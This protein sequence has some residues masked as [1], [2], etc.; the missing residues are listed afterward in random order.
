MNARDEILARA[1]QAAA[2][3]PTHTPGDT[4]PYTPRPGDADRFAERLANYR[5]LVTRCAP[6]GL[7][8]SVAAALAGV[9]AVIVPD[10]APR[11]WLAHYD[12]RVVTDVDA[13]DA[14]LTG[15]AAAVAETGTVI[16]DA[17]PAQGPRVL[18]LIP[19]HHICIVRA[20]QIHADVP[21]AVAALRPTA[22]QTW[23][24]GPS[25]TS[26]IE[27]DRVEGVHGPRRLHV[28]LVR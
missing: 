11:G 8:R 2:T 13:A 22:P 18:S 12:G 28:I 19:D 25:A 4:M 16:L 23:I 26:D 21:D 20:A 15:C 7:S 6:E 17:G 1:R 27:L 9:P 10:D 5:A 3:G 24:S 14:V